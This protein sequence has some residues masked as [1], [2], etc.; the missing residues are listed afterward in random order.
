MINRSRPEVFEEAGDLGLLQE[1][2]VEETAQDFGRLL[3]HR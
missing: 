3:S 2:R 1:A